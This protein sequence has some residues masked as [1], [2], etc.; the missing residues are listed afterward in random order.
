MKTEELE[1]KSEIGVSEKRKK[2]MYWSDNARCTGLFILGI[3]L[4]ILCLKTYNC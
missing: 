4:N 2:D 1:K 3:V